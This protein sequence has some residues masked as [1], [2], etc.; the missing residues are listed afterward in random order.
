MTPGIPEADLQDEV[1][2]LESDLIIANLALKHYKDEN[3]GLIR[4]NEVLKDIHDIQLE[5]LIPGQNLLGLTLECEQ[6]RNEN[7][8]L[9]GEL[10]GL[11]GELLC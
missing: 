11:R 7:N 10:I 5:T 1:I 3:I 4:E 6:I 9:K 2:R 8:D